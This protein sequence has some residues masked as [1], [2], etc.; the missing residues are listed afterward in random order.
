MPAV[1]LSCVSPLDRSNA[2]ARVMVRYSSAGASDTPAH[3]T[4]SRLASEP[5]RT[6]RAPASTSSP[7]TSTSAQS[8]PS[9]TRRVYR[10]ARSASSTC[11]SS[12][13]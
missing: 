10:S 3:A 4:S 8:P 2:A 5:A 13:R 11:R 6:A 9:T 7:R 1:D 12:A